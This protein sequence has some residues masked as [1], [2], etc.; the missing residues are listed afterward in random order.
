MQITANQICFNQKGVGVL[1]VCNKVFQTT[2]LVQ[3][4]S[5]ELCESRP[6]VREL[7]LLCQDWLD[8]I[9]SSAMSG[10]SSYST[11]YT[12]KTI[13]CTYDAPGRAW[14]A[15]AERCSCR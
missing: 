3:Q 12:S 2:L 11:N 5:T 10:K 13:N 7:R 14:R 4:M 1:D 9:R 15:A 6:A 8:R